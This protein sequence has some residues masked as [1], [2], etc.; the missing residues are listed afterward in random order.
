MISAGVTGSQ[1][2]YKHKHAPAIKGPNRTYL[3]PQPTDHRLADATPSP[4]PSRTRA[5]A[6][7]TRW[8]T[9]AVGPGSLSCT[10]RSGPRSSCGPVRTCFFQKAHLLK[11]FN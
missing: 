2:Q 6:P 11:D 4:S 10:L 8:L 9:F 1:H 5:F 3:I 7:A